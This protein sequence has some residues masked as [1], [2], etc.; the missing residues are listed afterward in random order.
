M[1]LVSESA[2]SNP[3]LRLEYSHKQNLSADIGAFFLSLVILGQDWG[4]RMGEKVTLDVTKGTVNMGW[5][6]CLVWQ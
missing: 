4:R 1:S 5:E 2:D 6:K 3:R